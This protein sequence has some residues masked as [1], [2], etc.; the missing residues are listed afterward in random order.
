MIYIFFREE[1]DPIISD[2]SVEDIII[3]GGVW[4][5]GE[6]GVRIWRPYHEIVMITEESDASSI[7]DDTRHASDDKAT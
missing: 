7:G 4:E 5:K 2:E 6:G 1:Q 3:H